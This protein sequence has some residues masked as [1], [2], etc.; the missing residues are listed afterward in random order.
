MF[1]LKKS[2]QKVSL[3]VSSSRH[4]DYDVLSALGVK[5]LFV[6]QKM[7]ECANPRH[8]Y[9]FATEVLFLKGNINKTHKE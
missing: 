2:E 1:I 8:N 3:S 9:K 4:C 6:A 5:T 7:F